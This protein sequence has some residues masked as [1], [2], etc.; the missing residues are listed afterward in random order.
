MQLDFIISD[1]YFN[2]KKAW[3]DIASP[4]AIIIGASTVSYPARN[5]K[6]TISTH[7]KEQVKIGSGLEQVKMIASIL[8]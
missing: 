1:A 6:T 5:H 8:P 3:Q 4:L 7:C 2:L